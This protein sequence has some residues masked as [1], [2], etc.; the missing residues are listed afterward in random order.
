MARVEFNY[1]TQQEELI[2]PEYGRVIQ[3]LIRK[4]K[5][6]EDDAYRQSFA[7]CVVDLM[8]TMTPYNRNLEEHRKKLWHHF[9]RIAKYDIN[10]DPPYGIVPS[11]DM[12]MLRPEKISYPAINDKFRHYGN[13]INQM[14]RKASAMEV[15]QKRDEYTLIIGSYMKLAYRNWNKEH[16]VNDEILI[17]D[18]LI[19]SKGQ[20][21]IPADASLDGLSTGV[22]QKRVYS[23]FP[24]NS[25]SKSNNNRFNSK[26]NFSRPKRRP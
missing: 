18:L 11:P 21:T 19:M 20:L 6:V 9:F 14:I 23:Q 15:G 24:T 8:Q 12:D 25:K 3:D 17:N 7:E 1:N 5:V 4:C 10:V 13:Y 16:Y 26:R 22:R 2:M